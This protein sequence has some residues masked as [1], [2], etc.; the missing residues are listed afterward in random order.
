MSISLFLQFYV[1]EISE[2]PTLPYVPLLLSKLFLMY[3]IDSPPPTTPPP[4]TGVNGM[5]G[6]PQSIT[7]EK[8]LVFVMFLVSSYLILSLVLVVLFLFIVS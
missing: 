2:S 3:F 6:F 1:I 4:H 5:C 8:I 7:Q